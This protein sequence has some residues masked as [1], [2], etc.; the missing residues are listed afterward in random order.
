MSWRFVQQLNDTIISLLDGF[1]E[2]LD[3]FNGDPIPD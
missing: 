3:F 2:F 1:Q